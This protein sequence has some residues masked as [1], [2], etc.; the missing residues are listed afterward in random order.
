MGIVIVEREPEARL[1]VGWRNW[2]VE[3][4]DYIKA[5]ATS[6]ASRMESSLQP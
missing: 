3:R 4:R 2:R 6:T 1:N 5:H